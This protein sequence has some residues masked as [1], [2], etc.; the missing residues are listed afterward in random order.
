MN[1]AD[2]PDRPIPNSY[3]VLP[4]R[5]AAGEYPGARYRD[6]AAAKLQ[7][8]LRAGIDHFVDLTEQHGQRQISGRTP[9]AKLGLPS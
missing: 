9:K 1:T 6:A 7:S 3:W 8:L 5:F 4:G 2:N